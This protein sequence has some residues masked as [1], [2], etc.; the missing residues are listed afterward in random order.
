M[1]MALGHP[2]PLVKLASH[3]SHGTVADDRKRG[4]NV[5]PPLD[6]LI[7]QPNPA[8]AAFGLAWQCFGHRHARPYLHK[9]TGRNLPGHM[10]HELAHGKYHAAILA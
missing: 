4:V 3:R 10:L 5:H 8:D 9:S 1:M 2:E 7:S 6:T